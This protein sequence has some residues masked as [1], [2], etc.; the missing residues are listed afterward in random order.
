MTQSEL[1]RLK[2]V[3][4]RVAADYLGVS[5]EFIRSGIEQNRLPFGACVTGASGRRIFYI[6]PE[7]L[8]DFKG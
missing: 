3:P 5:P 1:K 6:S 2:N 4:V 8:I 7:K